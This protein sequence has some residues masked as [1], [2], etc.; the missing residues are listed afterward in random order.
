VEGTNII[1]FKE[2]SMKD[3]F[4]VVIILFIFIMNVFALDKSLDTIWVDTSISKIEWVGNKVSGSHNGQVKIKNGYVLKREGLLV[5]GE[6]VVDMNS[7]SVDDIEHPD[8]NKSLV[9]H[10]KNED[11]FDV[12]KFPTSKLK[13]L[14]SKESS[15]KD[16]SN[17]NLEISSKLT[18]KDITHEIV[19]HSYVDFNAN[20][21]VGELIID[22][23]K[24]DIKYGSSSFFDNLGDRAIYNDFILNFHLFPK[25]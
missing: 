14:S 7:I 21:S 23:T 17:S 12:K 22:R 11:F 4:S 25:K 10:L 16:K 9:D 8:W 5:G 20:T 3:S 15:I 6:I 19:F 24:W 1:Y 18:I 2:V 13:I